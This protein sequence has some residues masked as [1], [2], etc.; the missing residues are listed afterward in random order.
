VTKTLTAADVACTDSL[1]A[2]ATDADGNTS[3]FA[4][5]NVLPVRLAAFTGQ[6]E[7]SQTAVLTW[8]T[9]AEQGNAGFRVEHERGTQ[10]WTSLGWK[11]G[12][13]TR[14][15]AQTYRF[16]VDDLGAGLHRFRLVQVDLDGTIRVH[17]PIAV[18]LRMRQA[19]RLARPAPNPASGTATV[20]FAVQEGGRTTVAM[21]NALGQRVRRLYDGRVPAETTRRLRVPVSDLASGVYFLR[22]QAGGQQRT[23]RL[24]VVH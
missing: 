18:R 4:A 15:D 8:T 2:T 11:E 7:G 22:L 9:A 19:L 17:G 21:Y 24:T 1:V 3:Q 12:G 16:T 13:G 23:R 10:G 5:P 20:S 6:Q 14:T